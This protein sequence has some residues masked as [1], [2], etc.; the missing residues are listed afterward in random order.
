MGER[1]LDL[2]GRCVAPER[3]LHRRHA[4][5]C[6]GRVDEERPPGGKI[7]CDARKRA[8]R[9]G[10]R[11]GC[12]ERI[13]LD[14]GVRRRH[15]SDLP[16]RRLGAGTG[17]HRGLAFDARHDG[18]VAALRQQCGGTEVLRQPERNAG[19]GRDERKVATRRTDRVQIGIG[20]CIDDHVRD[21]V[22]GQA[23][24]LRA[25]RVGALRHDRIGDE[26][27]AT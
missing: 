22:G 4:L 26:P 3:P 1:L 17:E 10:L 2:R 7:G 21:T 6:R 5:R 16:A 13:E 25:D 8:L 12:L 19:A 23:R 15:R 24:E 20:D 18:R 27:D 9:D 11:V 14:G